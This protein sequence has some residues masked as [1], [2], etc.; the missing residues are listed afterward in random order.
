LTDL[1]ELIRT[2]LDRDARRVRFE[3]SRWE[4]TATGEHRPRRRSV[5]RAVAGLAVAAL[6]TVAVG[7][8]LYLLS[9]LGSERD[10]PPATAGSG[11]Y[12]RHVDADD[13]L[14][15][16]IPDSWSFQANPTR[17]IE[18][19][20]V[21]AAGSWRF[22]R[23]GVCAPFEALRDLPT[24]GAF[25]WLIEYHGPDDPGDFIP[26]PRPFALGDKYGHY[27]CS[28]IHPTYRI[29]FQ[30]EDRFF[31]AHVALGRD[32]PDTLV[33]EVVAALDSLEVNACDAADDGYA[34]SPAPT[35]GPPGSPAAVSGELP[36][37]EGQESGFPG[38]P[39]THVEAWWNL[40]PA[41]WASALPGGEE[42]VPTGPGPVLRLGRIDFPAASCT[43]EIPF[44]V[45]AAGVGEYP[46]VVIAGGE[47]SASAL[48]AVRFTLT[49]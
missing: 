23:G 18:P 2:E 14:A 30:D 13:G 36:G 4:P 45:P 38:D 27:D 7:V 34:P 49:G 26:R 5:A 44:T 16:T 1:D 11:S 28:G 25:L 43:Y 41:E 15:M 17:P 3:A 35:S 9:P 24:D 33:R 20:N 6:I 12:V 40:D 31:Q 47:L 8:P 29:R 39:A 22:P 32:V 37:G 19:K 46:L 42:P 48:P 10:Q 21:L